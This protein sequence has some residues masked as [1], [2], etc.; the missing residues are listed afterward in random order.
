MKKFYLLVLFFIALFSCQKEQ[1]PKQITTVII[2]EV[3][4]RPYS[5]KLLL[6]PKHE[7]FRVNA[8]EIPIIKGKF[9]YILKSNFIQNYS[10]AF[11]DEHSKGTWR[12]INFFNDKDT[13][14]MTLFETEKSDFNIYYSWRENKL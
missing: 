2:G 11:E 9:K 10:L 3:I 5:K 1:K 13:I 6:I 8:I 7:D 12:A 4:N 14:L